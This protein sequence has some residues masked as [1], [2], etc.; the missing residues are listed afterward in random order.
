MSNQNVPFS[1]RL[2]EAPDPLT[3]PP[4]PVCHPCTVIEDA[5][6]LRLPLDTEREAIRAW[7]AVKA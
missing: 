1:F 5:R 2:E 7:Q 4:L 3:I 6:Q